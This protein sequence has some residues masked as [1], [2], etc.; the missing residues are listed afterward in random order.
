MIELTDDEANEI[1]YLTHSSH[2]SKCRFALKR[3]RVIAS[4]FKDCCNAS[5]EEPSISFINRMMNPIDNF[6]C[7]P[8]N[9]SA[10]MRKIFEQHYKAIALHH[11]E[12]EY[13]ECGLIIN[14]EFPYFAASPDKLI[15]CDCHGEGCIVINFLKIM[16]SAE[17]FDVLS[18]KPNR[19]LNKKQHFYELE[20]TG[21]NP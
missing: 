3:G 6:R 9:I 19:I 15:S 5:I 1:S 8:K 12:L 10:K 21:K 16:E 11:Q 13:H 18:I 2:K 14:P 20:K 7:Y 4:Y 17:S